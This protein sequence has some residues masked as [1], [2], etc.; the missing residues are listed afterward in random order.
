M[1][2]KHYDAQIKSQWNHLSYS[3]YLSNYASTRYITVQ[4]RNVSF[5]LLSCKKKHWV[6]CCFN[7]FTNWIDNLEFAIK[8]MLLIKL[9]NRLI[10]VDI[11]L[12][13][14]LY[15]CISIKNKLEQLFYCNKNWI[16]LKT[17][18]DAIKISTEDDNPRILTGV[19]LLKCKQPTKQRVN[20]MLK[21]ARSAHFNGDKNNR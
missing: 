6:N 9:Y 21:N 14:F 18:I 11:A 19:H 5:W 17:V 20:A 7:I 12:F 1:G 2:I 3:R 4:T 15:C 10:F 16:Y 8:I 13:A